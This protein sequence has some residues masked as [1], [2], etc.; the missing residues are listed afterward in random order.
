MKPRDGNGDGTIGTVD[1]DKLQTVRKVD[2]THCL[3]ELRGGQ[4]IKFFFEFVKNDG[5]F[6]IGPN[7]VI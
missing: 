1:Y 4:R 7:K 3:F 6:Q 5:F 2:G